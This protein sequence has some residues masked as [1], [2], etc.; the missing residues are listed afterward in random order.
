MLNLIQANV[1]ELTQMRGR[2]EIFKY[3]K[4][5]VIYITLYVYKAVEFKSC[6]YFE[7]AILKE[8][9]GCVL[10]ILQT[11]IYFT[12]NTLFHFM[13]YT[14]LKIYYILYNFDLN[15]VIF[16]VFHIINV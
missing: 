15:V 9:L 7:M 6:I 3:F 12:S 2:G 1:F 5:C 8:R 13:N 4:M 14:F 10:M 11:F 16:F